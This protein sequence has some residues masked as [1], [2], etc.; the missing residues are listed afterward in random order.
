MRTNPIRLVLVL[1]LAGVVAVVGCQ[2]Q[3]VLVPVS[4]KVTVK[5]RPL[6]HARVLF[7][8][9]RDKG[10]AQG[11]DAR[12]RVDET[13]SFSLTTRDKEGVVPGWY[14]VAIFAFEEPAP[15]AGPKPPVWLASMD[16]ADPNKSGLAVEVTADAEPGK[17][18]FDLTR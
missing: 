5:G 12:A 7:V 17:Y 15:G 6:K 10:N 3:P 1:L 18:D 8:P 9:D 16:Y 2:R 13:G 14:K 4:G 11:E